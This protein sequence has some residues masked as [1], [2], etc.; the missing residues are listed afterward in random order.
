MPPSLLPLV[1]L[2]RQTVSARQWPWLCLVMVS[3][4]IWVF[5]SLQSLQQLVWGVEMLWTTEGAV[6]IAHQKK[7][8][9]PLLGKSLH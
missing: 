9:G 4:A 6:G 7:T 5:S 2:S 3:L 8:Q 1:L